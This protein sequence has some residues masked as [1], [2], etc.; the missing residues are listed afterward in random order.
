MLAADGAQSQLYDPYSAVNGTAITRTPYPGNILPASELSPIALKY[1]NY[2]PPA[3]SVALRPDGFDNF[4]NRSAAIDNY[5]NELGRMDFNISAANRLS[6][7]VSHGYYDNFKNNYFEDIAT[8]TTDIRNSSGVTLDDVHMLNATNVVNV[9][10]GF[11]RLNEYHNQPSA[12]FDATTLGFPSYMTTQSYARS[13]PIATFSTFGTLD[14]ATYNTIPSQ[15]TQ[16]FGDLV[17]SKG[18][19]TLKFGGDG[20][21]TRLNNFL[22]NNAAGTF[23]FAGNSWVRQSSTSSATVAQ[24][25]DLASFLLGLPY[26]GSFDQNTSGFWYS[27]YLGVFAQD[28]WRVSRTLTVNLGVRFDHDAPYNEKYGRGVDGF[29]TTATNPLAAA[30]MAAYAKSPISQLPVSAFNVLGGLMYPGAGQT[31]IY[32][33]NS[34]LVSPRVGFAWAPDRF[35]G[36][37]A[38]RGGFGVFVAPLEPLQMNNDNSYSSTPVVNQE[39]FSQTTQMIVTNNNYL[40]PATTLSNPF[41]NGFQKAPGSS[42][43]MLTFA[44]QAIAFFDPQTRNPYTTRWNFGIQQ[45][46]SSNLALEVAYIG[47][48]AVH[49]SVFATQLNGLPRQY[50]STLPTRDPNQTYLS[51]TAANPFSGLQ[52]SQNTASTTAAQVLAPYPEFPIG[53]SASGFSGSGGVLEQNMPIGSASFNSLNVRLQKRF[54]QGLSLTFNY[55]YSKMIEADSWLNAENVSTSLERRVSPSDRPQRVTVSLSYELPFGRNKYFHL[56]SRWLNAV[57]GGWFFNTNVQRQ[58]GAPIVWNNAS[59]SSPGDYVYLGGPLDLNSRQVNGPAFNTAVFD[60]KSAD[61]FNYHLRTFS[62]TFGNVRADGVNQVDASMLKHF[63]VS[64]KTYFEFRFEA[65]NAFNHPVFSAPDITASD[66][67][68]GTITSVANKPRSIQLGARYVF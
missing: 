51:G 24:G 23:S 40:S 9:R 54:S 34:H 28:D 7:I 53:N 38:I 14:V 67:G 15:L 19:H 13:L 63:N 32:A 8:G 16:L 68:F 6:F 64:E 31:Q 44:G 33:S 56:Q 47:D 41:P 46:L 27:Y 57:V 58:S 30:A 29:N 55:I 61:A 66:S 43:G 42:L 11:D 59:T 52:T 65:Y 49:T 1:L 17:S 22:A 26:S 10:F 4:T 62:T 39:G 25:Q 2:Y 37:T 45:A 21:Q 20:R 60:T 5:N 48:H 12:G 3:N 35:H 36:K 50:L 18:K